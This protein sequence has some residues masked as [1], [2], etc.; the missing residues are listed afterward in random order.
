MATGDI[1]VTE[2]T[3]A[4]IGTYTITEDAISKDIQRN[5]LNNSAGTEIGTTANP[6]NITGSIITVGSSGASSVSGT[7]NALQ[8][9]G[10]VMAVNMP[11]PSIIA[12]QQ[13][14]S[15]LAVNMPS[16][17]VI[18]I[19]Q[20]GSVMAVAPGSVSGVGIFNVNHIGNGSILSVPTSSTI[21]VIQGSV[22]AFQGGVWATSIVGVP[23]PHS[24]SGVGQFQVNHNG[25]GSIITLNVGSVITVFKDSSILAVPVGSVLTIPTSSTIAIIQASSIAGTYTEDSAHGTNDRGIF[26]LAVRNDTMSSITSADGDYSPQITGPVGEVI[27]ANSPIT[28]WYS[29]QSSVM[30]GTSVQVVAAGGASVFNYL[31]GL[32]V[33]NDSGTF[34]RVKITGGLGSVLAWTVAPASG[35]SNINFI[36]PIRVGENMGISASISGVSSVY[37]SMQGFTSKT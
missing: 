8:L 1:K 14:G 5:V 7:V 26:T 33:A 36:N 29:S 25:N 19:Q 3:G 11:S 35:G 9:A 20:A 6:I 31:S 23:Q 27:T 13:A 34:S 28:K 30:Y 24:V 10:S 37:I 15:I 16:P 22:A 21:A 17:S 32:Q 2:G 12:T 18:A 4:N